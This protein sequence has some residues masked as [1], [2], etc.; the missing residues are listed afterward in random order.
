MAA[1][2]PSTHD[3]AGG[4]ADYAPA[5]PASA[6]H[7]EVRDLVA[8]GWH[9]LRLSGELDLVSTSVLADAVDRI[10]MQAV[11]G[12]TLDLARV[13]FMDSTGVRSVL[14][15][16]ERCGTT[17]TEFRIVPGPRAVQ[18]VF[19]VTGLSDRLPF[20][21]GGAARLAGD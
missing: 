8:G 7:L 16:A 21:Q 9:T 20:A 3:P 2:D 17:G 18:R 19:E 6:A 11:S 13:S 15:L 12:V 10:A 4:F 5:D 14:A 1:S